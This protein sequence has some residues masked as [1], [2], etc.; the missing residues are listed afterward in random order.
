MGTQTKARA[1][2]IAQE[3]DG[4]QQMMGLD[5]ITIISIITEL[6]PMII[7]C[8]DPDDGPQA[9]EYVE[10]RYDG[11]KSDDQYRGYTRSLARTMARRAKMAARK[12]RKRITWTQAYEMGFAALDDIRTGDPHQASVA[13]SENNDFMLI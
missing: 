4:R 3:L 11:S 1:N 6:L 12:E 8:F 9:Q 5:V 13:I 2:L 10:K 7:A